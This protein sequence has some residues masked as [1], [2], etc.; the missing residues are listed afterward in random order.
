MERKT[1]KQKKEELKSEMDMLRSKE[2]V[3]EIHEVSP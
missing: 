3:R 1:K 2:T